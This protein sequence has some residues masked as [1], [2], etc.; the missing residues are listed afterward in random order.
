[1][2]KLPRAREVV[3]V[4]QKLGFRFSRQKGSHA[5]YR[6]PDG[7]RITVPVHAGKEISPGVF[8]EI[9]TDLGITV[10]EFWEYA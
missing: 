4:V 10:K 2:A 1:V 9:L 7:R 8:R 3:K 5:I 6:H